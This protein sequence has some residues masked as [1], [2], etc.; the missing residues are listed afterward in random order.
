MNYTYSLYKRNKPKK[1]YYYEEELK[2]LTTLQLRD[3]CSREKIPIG[4]VYKLNRDYLIQMILKYRGIGIINYISSFNEDGYKKLF[5]KFERYLKPIDAENNYEFSA[6]IDL[7]LDADVTLNDNYIVSGKNLYEGNLFLLDDKN[8][9][10]GL[11]HLK[12]EKNNYYI[13]CKSMFLSESLNKAVY[14]T[15]SIGFLDEKASDAFY[16]DY[17][18]IESL[19]P[20]KFY[21]YVKKINELNIK[22]I[23]QSNETLVID[24][25]TSSTCAGVYIDNI[26]NKLEE[27]KKLCFVNFNTLKN[28]KNFSKTLPTVISV[29]DCKKEKNITY[30][31]GYDAVKNAVQNS[32]SRKESVF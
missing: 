9:I 5:G 30:R 23:E 27:N 6:L 4:A 21:C 2:R 3:I 20:A 22:K 24:F 11:L 13:T 10:V 32:F 7:Y 17:Y 28:Q 18:N 8:K 14:K 12:K 1:T 15:Y 29:K 26:K 19:K 31:F 16:R 25:G